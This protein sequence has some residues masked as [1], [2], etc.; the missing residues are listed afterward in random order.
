MRS[1]N[2]TKKNTPYVSHV[3]MSVPKLSMF[4]RLRRF[5]HTC[6]RILW[7]SIL[8]LTMTSHTSMKTYWKRTLCVTECNNISMLA[9]S[10][11]SSCDLA[12]QPNYVRLL[13]A[14]PYEGNTSCILYDP[15]Q[16][17]ILHSA[18]MPRNFNNIQMCMRF[19]RK[20]RHLE[21]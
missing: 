6:P 13:R 11:N 7:P 1:K 14:N 5:A 15:S 16:L 12:I 17:F 3:R 10:T 2:P 19:I 9:S 21:I 20:N 8:N 4:V 18:S